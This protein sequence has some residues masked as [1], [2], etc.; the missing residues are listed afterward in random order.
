MSAESEVHH[1]LLLRAI[2][3]PESMLSCNN[4]EWE[5][6]LSMARRSR[7]LGYLATELHRS[8]SL[9][10]I[11][12]RVTR[13]LRCRLAEISRLHDQALWELNRIGWALEGSKIPVIVLKGVAYLFADLPAAR[14]RYFADVDLLIPRGCMDEFESLLLARG[15]RHP[16]LS[17]YDDHYYRAWSHEIPALVHSERTTEIDAHHTLAPLTSRI[18]VDAQA[19]FDRAISAGH[20]DFKILCPVDMALHCA[21]NLFQNNVLSDDLRD[22]LDL[23]EMF[24]QFSNTDPDFWMLLVARANDLHLGE[25]LFYGIQFARRL[26]KTPVP[27]NVE[28][29]LTQRPYRL[30]QWLMHR[31]VPLALLPLH[32]E[33]PSYRARLARLLL[34]YRSHW[35]RMPLHLLVVHVSYKFW[36]MLLSRSGGASR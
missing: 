20:E 24:L 19:L 26:L 3:K 13:I 14:G 28:Q 16:Q 6:L 9:G 30:A 1:A 25:P 29:G 5:L 12:A 17:A 10:K 11:P 34:F 15:W 36:G 31:L 33:A 7:L 2:L 4:A 8:N 23:H 35:I 18:K 21:V 22:L 27:A 32:P